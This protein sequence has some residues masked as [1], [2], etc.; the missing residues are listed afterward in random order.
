MNRVA[1]YLVMLGMSLAAVPAAK[2][3]GCGC[4]R[5]DVCGCSSQCEKTCKLIVGTKTVP[6]V[7]YCVECEDICIPGPSQR[8]GAHCECDVNPCTGC[9]EHHKSFDWI[10]NPCGCIRTKAKL[11]KIETPKQVKTYKWVVVH[12]CG[13]CARCGNLAQKT[14]VEKETQLAVEETKN[15]ATGE[16]A[17]TTT[18]AASKVVQASATEDVA[19]QGE[20]KEELAS[21]G[22]VLKSKLMSLLS[23]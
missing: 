7:T 17:P 8:C 23:K 16:A 3:G 5:C 6:K 11:V 10:P 18:P 21:P 1:I 20:K 13:N 14:L 12:V 2:A 22:L 9:A 4:E 19:A 15:P